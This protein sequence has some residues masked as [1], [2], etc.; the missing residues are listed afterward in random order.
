MTCPLPVSYTHL[1]VYKRQLLIWPC[2]KVLFSFVVSSALLACPNHISCL[3][4]SKSIKGLSPKFHLSVFAIS[5]FFA[6]SHMRNSNCADV[7]LLTC[8]S[9]I[10]QLS[11]P[12]IIVVMYS[13]CLLYTSPCE[14][15][16]CSLWRYLYLQD[17]ILADSIITRLLLSVW[18]QKPSFF[19]REMCIRDSAWVMRSLN[20]A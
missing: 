14:R 12:Y 18:N 17:T 7:I 13:I 4:S 16:W 1:D 10:V 6:T 19:T 2:F 8:L 20:G 15:S 5:P 3:I 11:A 9:R